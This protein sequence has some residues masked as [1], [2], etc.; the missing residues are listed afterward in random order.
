MCN[1]GEAEWLPPRNWPGQAVISTAFQSHCSPFLL[2]RCYREKQ[3]IAMGLLAVMCVEEVPLILPLYGGRVPAGFPSPAE[4]Y[5]E[6]Q[7]LGLPVSRP[8]YVCAGAKT[9]CVAMDRHPYLRRPCTDE[10]ACEARQLLRQ[11]EA[12]IPRSLRSSGAATSRSFSN[13]ILTW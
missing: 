1:L 10:D 9:T 4:D 13:P 11:T 2:P 7:L 8:G 5:L 6:S 3:G 12:C